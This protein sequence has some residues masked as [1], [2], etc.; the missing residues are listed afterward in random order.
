M[1]FYLRGSGPITAIYKH[2]QSFVPISYFL[3]KFQLLQTDGPFLNSFRHPDHLYIIIPY[4][5]LLVLRVTNNRIVN[6]TINLH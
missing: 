1:E 3:L 6:K 5:S 4:I 2:V